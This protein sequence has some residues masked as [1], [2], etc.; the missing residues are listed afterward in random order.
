MPRVIRLSPWERDLAQAAGMS[1]IAVA[2]R[3]RQRQDEHPIVIA[4]LV[5][6]A[7]K[8]GH[9]GKKGMRRIKQV[10][11][12][13]RA[14]GWTPPQEPIDEMKFQDLIRGQEKENQRRRERSS[15]ERGRR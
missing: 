12:L 8:G 2:E 9:V 1:E 14:A 15:A 11:A 6:Y 7:R 13:I 10:I 4:L 3:K 5:T